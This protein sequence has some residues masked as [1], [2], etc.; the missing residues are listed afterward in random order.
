MWHYCDVYGWRGHYFNN[1]LYTKSL[2]L[3]NSVKKCRC[4][5]TRNVIRKVPLPD[6]EEFEDYKSPASRVVDEY[7]DD[8][9]EGIFNIGN[10]IKIFIPLIIMIVIMTV[11]L[12]IVTQMESCL[13]SNLTC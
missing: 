5:E 11:L 12:P 4:G 13:Q 10:I 9:G 1:P 7:A 8:D 6:T 3:V 2:D